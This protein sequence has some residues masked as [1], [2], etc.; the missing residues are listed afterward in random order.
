MN[1]EHSIAHSIW[2]SIIIK[3]CYISNK[4]N[5]SALDHNF[6]DQSFKLKV[7]ALWICQQA[8]LP[9]LYFNKLNLYEQWTLYWALYTAL[10]IYDDEILLNW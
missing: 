5:K 7:S 2:K 1:N 10:E 3:F 9:H 8:S 4:N 6:K